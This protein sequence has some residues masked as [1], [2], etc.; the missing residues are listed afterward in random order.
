[1]KRQEI[2]LAARTYLDT[3]YVHLG[4]V[5]GA[6]IDCVGLVQGLLAGFGL[7]HSDKTQYTPTGGGM[8]SLSRELQA[9]LVPVMFV[10]LARPGD[11]LAFWINRAGQ[12][13]HC[14]VMTDRG[15]LHTHSGLKRVVEHRMD[16]SWTKRLMEVY[17][18]PNVED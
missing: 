11:V 8:L 4:R 2:I 1:M 10:H 13:K 16:A 9:C 14:G 17:R 15:L 12:A 3:P 5:K 6:G 18:F 7:P